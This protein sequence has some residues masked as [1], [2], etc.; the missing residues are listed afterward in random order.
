MKQN[1]SLRAL[2]RGDLRF[3]HNLNNNRNIMSYWFEE[4]Y[5]S[6]DELEELYN[7]HIHDN[8]ERRFVVEDENKSLIGLVEII[9][10]DY[11]HRSAEFQIIIT[12]EH[13]GKGYANTLI[14]KALDYSFTILNL[15]K[16]YL[17]VA[18]ENEKALHLYQQCGFIEEGHLVEEFFINGQYRDVKR[19]YILQPQYLKQTRS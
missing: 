5:E 7:K 15:H 1:L 13:Q 17:H 10:I 2:E 14:N 3:I 16:I 4:P 9:E 8:A 11:I 6:F 18:I 12:P 19:M